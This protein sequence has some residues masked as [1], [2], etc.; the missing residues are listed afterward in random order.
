[1]GN[2]P[3]K[4]DILMILYVWF[5][6]NVIIRKTINKKFETEIKNILILKK[7]FLN[8]DVLLVIMDLLEVLLINVQVVAVTDNYQLEVVFVILDFMILDILI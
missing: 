5:A 6:K 3:V 8:K 7:L 4:M 2:V 1:V